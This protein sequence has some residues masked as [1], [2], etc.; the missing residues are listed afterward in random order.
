MADDLH[1]LDASPLIIVRCRICG[2]MISSTS[3][4]HHVH[5][6]TCNIGQ[7]TSASGGKSPT[8]SGDVVEKENDPQSENLRRGDAGG[9]VRSDSKP[10]KQDHVRGHGVETESPREELYNY[11]KAMA[12]DPSV[13]AMTDAI[14]AK[15]QAKM[16]R[17]AD[18]IYPPSLKNLYSFGDGGLVRWSEYSDPAVEE[19]QLRMQSSKHD[20]VHR[21]R[22]KKDGHLTGQLWETDSIIVRGKEL[23]QVFSQIFDGYPI[24][25]TNVPELKFSP[26]FEPII[27]RWQNIRSIRSQTHTMIKLDPL[28]KIFSPN[29]ETELAIIE[30]IKMTRKCRWS[31]L[32]LIFAPGDLF[33]S[34]TDGAPAVYRFHNYRMVEP[35]QRMRY[36]YVELEFVD[37][38]G[39][40]CGYKVQKFDI[41][42][43]K[44]SR[45]L[46]SLD[47]I[48]FSFAAD[49]DKLQSELVARGRI[50]EK[51]RGFHFKSYKGTRI[52]HEVDNWGRHSDVMKPVSLL[53]IEL[54]GP[55]LLVI[56]Q[57]CRHLAG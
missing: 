34:Y 55:A 38:N 50:F 27:H 54:I 30:E 47:I 43:Y 51:L 17:G 10:E 36:W 4:R 40:C 11:R 28:I 12:T 16:S 52:V 33:L 14:G 2:D 21:Q 22:P 23:L 19:R 49:Q 6:E 48:P 13:A 15:E 26:P 18:D 8:Q 1:P 24:V 7:E 41:E 44:G 39:R 35:P 9:A 46:E 57:N 31:D 37:W 29:I 20:I 45:R 25:N 5:D 56:Y 3:V 42:E 53:L 32:W